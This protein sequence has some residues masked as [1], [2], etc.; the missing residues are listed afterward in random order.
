MNLSDKEAKLRAI[1]RDCGA[2]AVAWSGGADSTLLAAVAHAV[3]GERLL[4]LTGQSP[5]LAP[6]EL[7][8]ARQFAER[9]GWR[10][11]TVPVRE[12]EVAAYTANPPDRCYHCKTALFGTLWP[13]ARAA[14]IAA[15]A[16]GDNA[17]DANGHRPGRRAAAEQGVRYPLQQAGLTKAEVRELSRRLGLPT[18]DKPAMACL[19]SRFPYGERL[20][21]AK[22]QRVAAAEGALRQR[23]Y[24]GFRVRSHGDLARLEF[25][26]G[27]LD[28]AWAER[29]ELVRV[30]RAAGF[31]WV[32]LDLQGFR[33]GAMNEG[34]GAAGAPA[35][36]V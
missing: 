15:L 32:T 24:R 12:L 18:W 22:M 2:L 7:D 11:Q 13:V 8:F 30:L 26:D 27:D 16:A 9:Q 19:A 34:L 1:L 4:V 5:S 14:G 25:G 29:E 17:D 6:E 3:L 10:W 33:S 31:A 23:G 21:A 36:N 35:P 28:R 20:D